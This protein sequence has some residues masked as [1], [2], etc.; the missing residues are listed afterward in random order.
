MR[1]DWTLS[2]LLVAVASLAALVAC[3]PMVPQRQA[4]Q[5]NR[6]AG[7]E[8]TIVVMPLDVELFELTA[9]G[10]QEPQAEWTKAARQ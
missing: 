9:G 10:V 5:L 7:T 4:P 2:R 3:A 1:V 8:P 6:E